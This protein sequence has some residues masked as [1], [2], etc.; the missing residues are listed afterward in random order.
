MTLEDIDDDV[1]GVRNELDC[2]SSHCCLTQKRLFLVGRAPV[3]PLAGVGLASVEF[4]HF[5]PRFVSLRRKSDP[6]CLFFVPLSQRGSRSHTHSRLLMS[7]VCMTTAW[8]LPKGCPFLSCLACQIIKLC[9]SHHGPRNF[10][11]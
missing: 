9:L 6:N 7:L 11:P 8:T 1:L 3:V 4:P 10:P 5:D 2:F